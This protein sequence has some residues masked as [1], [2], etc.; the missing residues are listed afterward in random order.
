MLRLKVFNLIRI[1]ARLIF[2]PPWRIAIS[3]NKINFLATFFFA[4]FCF[5]SAQN[6]IKRVCFVHASEPCFEL[7]A[8][9][10]RPTNN[11]CNFEPCDSYKKD[12]WQKKLIGSIIF[13]F[14]AISKYVVW[15]LLNSHATQLRM[16]TIVTIHKVYQR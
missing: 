15:W 12:P 8:V 1:W 3:W 2:H 5:F 7:C 11:A 16:P 13:H 10:S 9:K 14:A 4:R 6:L